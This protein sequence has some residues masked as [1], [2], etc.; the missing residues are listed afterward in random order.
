MAQPRKF[1]QFPL[2]S[3]LSGNELLL[4]WQGLGNRR[5]TL[6]TLKAF[7]GDGTE[8]SSVFLNVKTFDA[9][10]E[11]IMDDTIPIQTTIDNA[12]GKWVYF[13]EGDYKITSTLNLPVGTKIFGYGARVFSESH[14]YMIDCQGDN[15]IKGLEIE[16]AGSTPFDDDGRAINFVGTVG[17]YKSGLIIEDC[18]I[19]DIGFYGI[20]HHFASGLNVKNTK[21]FD[22]GYAGIMGLSVKDALVYNCH[23]K[24]IDYLEGGYGISF[25]RFTIPDTLEAHPRSSNCTVEN[26][27]VEDVLQ[28]KAYDT[29]G[30]DNIRFINN[31]AVNC[32]QGIGIVSAGNIAPTNCTAAF[33]TIITSRG[34][35]VGPT[36]SAYGIVVAGVAHDDLSGA[37]DFAK[38]NIVE[39]NIMIGCGQEGNA[40][41][42][43]IR[44]R[45]SLNTRI[46]GNVIDRPLVNGIVITNT[47]YNFVVSGNAVQD[48]NSSNEAMVTMSIKVVSQYNTGLILNNNTSKVDTALNLKVGERGI[49]VGTALNNILVIKS[50]QST[51]DIKESIPLSTNISTDTT[52]NNYLQINK[53]SEE[54]NLQMLFD[55]QFQIRTSDALGLHSTE[56]RA[57]FINGPINSTIF[58]GASSGS[59][60]WL[61]ILSETVDITSGRLRVAGTTA[62][63]EPTGIRQNVSGL[64]E[65]GNVFKNGFHYTSITDGLANNYPDTQ[66]ISIV[67]KTDNSRILEYFAN[68]TGTLWYRTLTTTANNIWKKVITD[69]DLQ[70][71]YAQTSDP[72]VVG[73]IWNNNGVLTFSNGPIV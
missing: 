28:W 10:G 24:G 11:G 41:E 61:G 51:C 71:M 18:F 4:T 64:A 7:L 21:I 50:N 15:I 44:M 70:G 43:A 40:N 12:N 36:W 27:L 68:T 42:G 72:E 19:H 62:T 58:V 48:A 17:L 67:F 33:N 23:I 8:D 13:P 53:G 65:S 32:R 52:F 9:T 47:N 20:Y 60:N 1:P 31:K 69:F 30:G 73:A 37:V 2:A 26:C 22:V 55:E 45:H 29:H 63:L 34:S 54:F 16:G 39:G 49:N 56:K 25:T 35:D 57:M 38:N 66:G 3:S 5:V 14:I 59:L 46:V 6:N